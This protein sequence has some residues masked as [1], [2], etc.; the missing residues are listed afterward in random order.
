M[1]KSI[2][3]RCVA[4][5]GGTKEYIICFDQNKVMINDIELQQQLPKEID[6]KE[7]YK[8]PCFQSPFDHRFHYY[9]DALFPGISDLDLIVNVLIKRL[10]LGLPLSPIYTVNWKTNRIEHGS[11]VRRLPCTGSEMNDFDYDMTL[12]P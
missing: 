9:S 5:F 11:Y 3:L 1:S 6:I 7:A 4:W 8:E 10:I 12:M 2:I